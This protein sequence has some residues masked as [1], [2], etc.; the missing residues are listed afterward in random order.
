MVELSIRIVLSGLLVF[1]AGLT[2]HPPFFAALQI[3]GFQVALAFL[4]S[5][6][7]KNQS[8][9]SSVAA[10][11]A[12]ADSIMISFAL[13][14]TGLP[15]LDNFAI[16]SFAPIVFS[17]ARHQA[18]PFLMAPIAAAGLV[19]ANMAHRDWQL[20]T[21]ESLAAALCF[22]A[23]G[24]LVRPLKVVQPVPQ[25]EIEEPVMEEGV[26]DIDPRTIEVE[27]QLLELRETYRLLSDAYRALSRKS[28]KDRVAAVLSE[29]QG[30]H[31]GNA[32]FR[33][34]DKIA[35]ACGCDAV[36]L[37][38]A[39]QIG[40]N[41]VLRGAYGNLSEQQ[42]TEAIPVK[43][44][45]SVALIREQA[46]R[47]SE[48]MESIRPCN[49]IIL[50]LEGK[51]VGLLTV[52]GSDRDNLFEAT[53]TLAPSSELI[54]RMVSVEEH[55]E[56]VERR[57]TETEVL[58]AVVANAEG[59]ST[60]AEVAARV[61]RDFQSVLNLEHLAIYGINGD[62]EY[63]LAREGRELSVV[64]GMNFSG[65]LGVEGWLAEGA[66]EILL[67]DAR[68]SE[69]LE[70]EIIVKERVGS[71]V[72]IPIGNPKNPHGFISAASG[73]IAGIDMSEVETLR[74][75]AAELSR[76]FERPENPSIE[77]EGILSPRQFVDKVGKIEGVMVTLFPMQLKELTE[78]YG[79]PA[80]NHALRTMMLRIRP[81]VPNGAFMCRHQDGMF[82]VYLP[83]YERDAAAQW[84]NDVASLNPT[85]GIKTPDGSTKI[86]MQL[87]VK[88]AAISPQLNQFLVGA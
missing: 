75:A 24:C 67:I 7:E 27:N 16:L 81:Y 78:R 86:P 35:E 61:A 76:I 60:R 6:L 59:A 8:R 80:I 20:P 47:I 36:L 54:A 32:F 82:M 51:V 37:Y 34:C 74:A 71:C 44:K 87:R 10:L 56:S 3:A 11:Q 84:A 30:V 40:D 15:Y 46:D 83:G 50:Q 43:P 66:N 57:L 39:T 5:R 64:Q 53:E 2:S 45:Q 48:S 25:S 4:C 12:G 19:A 73:R 70:K 41:F 52:I 79:K 1:I 23:V 17:A 38:T 68:S 29:S 88:V 49:N 63:L 21:G 13:G 42:L 65:K 77:D 69:L 55:R 72:V 31:S 85:A 9:T 62:N 18:N 14:A 58:Y 26:F 33:L 28:R 22:L